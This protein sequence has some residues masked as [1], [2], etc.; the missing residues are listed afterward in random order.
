DTYKLLFVSPELLQQPAIKDRLNKVHMSLIV[1]DE[2]HCISQWGYDFRPDYLRLQTIAQ[3]NPN[4]LILALTGTATKTVL[5]DIVKTL[6]RPEMVRHT[7][8]MERDN[9]TFVVQKIIGSELDKKESLQTCLT[10]V[11]APTIIYF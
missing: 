6:L 5:D 10:Q 4:V 9:I 11:N 8:S 7:Y 3:S 2:A 1:I